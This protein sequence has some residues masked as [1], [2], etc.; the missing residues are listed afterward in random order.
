MKLSTKGRYGLR[1]LIDL[2][3]Y[4]E[5]ETVSIQSIA[6]RQ[7]ISDSYLEQLMRK[8]RSAGLIVSV[9]GAQGG[10]KLARPA[11]EISVGDVLRALEGS[12][13]AVTCGGED[14]SCQGADLCVTKFVWERINS[15]IR[16]TVDSIKLSQLVEE[17]RLMREKGQIQVQKCDN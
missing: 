17:S 7:N 10:Y 5:N 8:L 13:E 4:S 9:R 2:A 16:D 12:L 3:L 14:N 1:A 11:N 15:S 6:R